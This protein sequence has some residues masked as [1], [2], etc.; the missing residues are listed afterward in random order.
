MK[1]EDGPG[2]KPDTFYNAVAEAFLWLTA[3]DWKSPVSEIATANQVDALTVHGWV[4]EARRRRLLMPP[5]P[6]TRHFKP[7]EDA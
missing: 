5:M 2:R 3:A 4:K 1:F 7:R 6:P